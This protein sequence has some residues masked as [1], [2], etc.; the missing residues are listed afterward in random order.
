[1]SIFRRML[2][3]TSTIGKEISSWIRSEGWFR[4]EA[5]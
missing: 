2:I 5:W 1:M 3:I 4:S